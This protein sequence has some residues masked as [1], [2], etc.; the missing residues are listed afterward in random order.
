[1]LVDGPVAQALFNTDEVLVA[2]EDLVNDRSV[3]RDHGLKE[4][5]YVHLLLP[6]H[7]VVWANGVETESFHPASTDMG[8]I[9]PDQRARLETIIPGLEQDPY[10]YGVP[11]PARAVAVRG[12]DPLPRGAH[13]PLT[14]RESGV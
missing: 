12:R 10:C 13:R 2:A 8:T 5:T 14:G 4:V 7:H 6:R 1:M 11:V 3:Y 9:R